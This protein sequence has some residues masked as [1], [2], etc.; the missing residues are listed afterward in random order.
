[1]DA[2][3]TSAH[4]KRGEGRPSSRRGEGFSYQKPVSSISRPGSRPST[5]RIM[6]QTRPGTAMSGQFKRPMSGTASRLASS[7]LS[8][9]IRIGTG[10]GLSTVVNVMDRP[11]TQQ[12]LSGLSSKDVN[13]SGGLGSGG[14][15]PQRQVKDVSYFMGI[16]RGKVGELTSEIARLAQETEAGASQRATLALYDKRAKEMAAELTELRGQLSDYN[17]LLDLVNTGG[18]ES[19]GFGGASLWETES[20]LAEL[21]ARND[22][23]SKRVEELFS[24]RKAAEDKAKTLSDQIEKEHKGAEML[25]ESLSEDERTLYSNLQMEEAKMQETIQMLQSK[26][27]ALNSERDMLKTKISSSRARQD[28][29]HLKLQIQEA[30]ERRDSLIT[31]SVGGLHGNVNQ[32]SLEEERAR[33]LERVKKDKMEAAKA[34]QLAEE[35]EEQARRL[36]QELTSFQQDEN[37]VSYSGQLGYQAVRNKEKEIDE[38]PSNADEQCREIE[39]R[40]ASTETVIVETLSTLSKQLSDPSFTQPSMDEIWSRKESVSVVD[41]Q[42]GSQSELRNKFFNRNMAGVEKKLMNEIQSL[43]SK[44]ASIE[45]DA[46]AMT[47]IETVK[48]QGHARLKELEEERA[49]LEKKMKENKKIEESTSAAIAKYEAIKK[50]LEDD[51]QWIFL[52]NLERKLSQAKQGNAALKEY[53]EAKKREQDY[54]VP[55]AQAI[56]N[57]SAVQ[58]LLK[59]NLQPMQLNASVV[60]KM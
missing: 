6:N 28:A 17:L 34:M 47:D 9:Q 59:N 40:I 36:R 23:E 50:K 57:L 3:S 31:S 1:M 10:Y 48:A 32:V 13:S 56:A 24:V 44:I 38:L 35:A 43:R 51:N 27:N 49:I 19:T 29:V 45:K 7:V 55:K 54:S 58:E 16:L 25:I 37:Y 30:M 39:G 52:R 53:I 20:A 33:L 2:K 8:Q 21:K 14:R 4:D 18:V 60:G 12:G 26:L 22:E 11:V 15:G 41:S 46:K 42:V 5:A